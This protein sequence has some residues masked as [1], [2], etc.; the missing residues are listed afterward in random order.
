[1]IVKTRDPA[2]TADGFVTRAAC[3]FIDA[4]FA[5]PPCWAVI[6]ELRLCTGTR[7]VEI[8]HVLIDDTLGI[9]VLDMRFIGCGLYLSAHSRCETFDGMERR[10]VASPL[11]KMARDMRRLGE[12]LD[13]IEAWRSATRC[14]HPDHR[15][16]P[17]MRGCVLIDPAFRLGA[18]EGD[19][20]ERIGIHSREA[21][22]P[23]LDKQRR[24]RLRDAPAP[25]SSAALASL[26]GA[27]AE[28]H[29]PRAIL[30]RRVTS[31]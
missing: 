5:E 24:R 9:V 28:R 23:M 14:P 25:L 26:A 8:D 19:P 10:L 18:M 7:A 29:R 21:I 12:E 6:H 16:P 15:P 4:R 30:A 17:P 22:F 13:G 20:R 2:R 31:A 3:D 11:A 27:L 1:M